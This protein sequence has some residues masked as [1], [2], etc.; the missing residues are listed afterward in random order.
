MLVVGVGKAVAALKRLPASHHGVT[1]RRPHLI[2]ET[3]SS[4]FCLRFRSSPLP[5]L[6]RLVM[7]E[8][9]QNCLAPHR[10]VDAFNGQR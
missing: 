4:G 7:L 5:Q 6:D 2:H 3:C 9:G 1:E 10:A 8:F